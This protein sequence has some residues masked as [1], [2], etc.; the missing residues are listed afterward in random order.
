M[1]QRKQQR[2][3]LFSCMCLVPGW[4]STQSSNLKVNKL[5]HKKKSWQS[6][7]TLCRSSI[8]SQFLLITGKAVI[9][10]NI[11]L[12]AISF[13]Q[14][15]RV[16]RRRSEKGEGGGSSITQRLND[17]ERGQ[18]IFYNPNDKTNRKLSPQRLEPPGCA[19]LSGHVLALSG[20]F[21]ILKGFFG[22]WKSL[23]VI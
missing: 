22:Y 15:M 17:L 8:N 18:E 6:Q 1:E 5:Y 12:G 23:K 16:V 2:S 10:C 4:L 11:R 9:Y 19:W 7:I 3:R 14:S 20:L 21:S 13:G